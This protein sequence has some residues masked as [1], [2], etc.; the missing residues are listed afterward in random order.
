M[1]VNL[2]EKSESE[3]ERER[4]SISLVFSLID[5]HGILLIGAVPLCR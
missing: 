2:F 3:R 5:A 4:E 1:D